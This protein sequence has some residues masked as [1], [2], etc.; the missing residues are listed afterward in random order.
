MRSEVTSRS[1]RCQCTSLTPRGSIVVVDDPLAL[2]QRRVWEVQKPVR[3]GNHRSAHRGPP[4]LPQG[5][6]MDQGRHQSRSPA[7]CWQQ[8]RQAR[9]VFASAA[10]PTDRSAADA[11]AGAM[12]GPGA[13]SCDKLTRFR[14]AP[15]QRHW[16]DQSDV[17]TTGVGRAKRI[18][19]R[20]IV[21]F[22]LAFALAAGWA[23]LHAFPSTR[24]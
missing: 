7:L 8:P 9:E 16:K 23:C 10:D 17:L 21:E 4:Q 3:R 15:H 18:G 22:G 20:F 14:P 11:G 12:A 1:N 19:S 13:I 5:R 2:A 24:D 6:E